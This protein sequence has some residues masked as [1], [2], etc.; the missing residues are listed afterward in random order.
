MR[1]IPIL[2]G[3][4]FGRLR[5]VCSVRKTGYRS[6][7]MRCVCDCGGQTDVLPDAL[8][9]GR[10]QSCGCRR[11]E[12]LDAGRTKHG[13]NLRGAKSKT[14]TTWAGMI[15]RCYDLTNSGYAYYGARGIRVCTRW[16]LFPTFLHDMGERPEGLTIERIDNDGDYEPGNCRW[17]TRAEQMQNIRPWGTCNAR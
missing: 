8:R 10:T 11:Q 17:A 12:T 2:S 9:D 4:R 5:V 6:V 7:R 16:R 13:H 15:G 3:T 1:E 14:Y